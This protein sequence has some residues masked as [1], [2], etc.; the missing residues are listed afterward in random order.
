MET[1]LLTYF[2]CY[3]VWQKYFSSQQEKMF[4]R[5]ENILPDKQKYTGNQHLFTDS[6]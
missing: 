1:D 6:K 2:R 3:S 5:Q 4:V